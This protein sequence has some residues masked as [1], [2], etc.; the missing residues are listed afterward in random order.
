MSSYYEEDTRPRR[1]RSTR[2]RRRPEYVEEVYEARGPIA[3]GSG[4]LDLVRR[5]D[6]S[7]SS[8]EEV[9][10]DFPPGGDAYVKRKVVRESGRRR[11]RSAERG[12][13]A[14]DYYSDDYRRPRHIGRGRV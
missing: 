14:D 8:I 12:R 13:Y 10:R 9:P 7:V 5:R 4:G 3:R 6:G 1:H 2:E 11:A